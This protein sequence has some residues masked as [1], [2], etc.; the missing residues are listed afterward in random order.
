MNL[1]GQKKKKKLPKFHTIN[2]YF[3]Q[4]VVDPFNI[5]KLG[6]KQVPTHIKST[7]LKR[8]TIF[9]LFHKIVHL[10]GDS[11]RGGRE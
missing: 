11:G 8:S 1:A 5:R 6:R 9:N 2:T 4:Q 10:T 7:A 3:L